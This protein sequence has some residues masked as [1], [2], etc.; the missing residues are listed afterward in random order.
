M[1]LWVRRG[2]TVQLVCRPISTWPGSWTEVRTRSPFKAPYEETRRLLERELDYLDATLPVVELAIGEGDLRLD[3]MIRANARPAHPGV[4]VSF[5]SCF[6]PLRY[7]TDRYVDWHSNL[8]AIALGLE[9]LRRV[10]RYGITKTG[11]QYRGWQALGTG[12]EEPM[13]E[14]DAALFV[15]EQSGNRVSTKAIRE[16]PSTRDAC[17]RKAAAIL[18]PDNPKTGNEVG[19]KRL[20]KAKEI[21]DKASEIRKGA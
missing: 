1:H 7:A 9:A 15:A 12:S 14:H 17:Y 3:G 2:E 20:V 11:E 5:G 16:E 21:L 18:H 10:D 13:S 4:V 6:G 19:F 8:R